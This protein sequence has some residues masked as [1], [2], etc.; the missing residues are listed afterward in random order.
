ML[1][2]KPNRRPTAEELLNLKEV[3]D[4]IDELYLDEE[5]EDE[6]LEKKKPLLETIQIPDKMDDL[7]KKL[8]ESNYTY[9]ETESRLNYLEQE[10]P[11]VNFRVNIESTREVKSR[12]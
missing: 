3:K 6:C 9:D 12:K 11:P 10:L 1:Q 4:K 8:P 5:K 7:Q 2:V